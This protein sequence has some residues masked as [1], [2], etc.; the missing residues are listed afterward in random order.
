MRK[1]VL[2]F[3]LS[4]ILT[5]QINAAEYDFLPKQIKNLSR[6]RL[7]SEGVRTLLDEGIQAIDDALT[8]GVRSAA[9]LVLIAL[10][11]ALTKGF[12]GAESSYTEI[13]GV[14]AVSGVAAGD[15]GALIGA[16][17]R[18]IDDL[19]VLS[20]SL[21]PTLAI[22]MA[23]GGFVGTASVLQ[24]GTL[25]AAN[26]LITLIRELLLPLC[27][28]C[29]GL[30]AAAAIVPESRLGNFSSGLRKLISGT[31]CAMTTLFT[32]FLTLGGVLSGSADKM[33][34]KIA[35][36]TVSAAIP[37]VG[38]ILSE[39]SE[40]VLAGAGAARAVCG[41]LGIFAVLF[42]CLS[43][44][45]HLCIQYFLYKITA[46]LAASAGVSALDKYIEDI[47]SIFGLVLGM[48]GSCALLFLVSVLLSITMAVV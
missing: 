2:I 5:A 32:L 26:F 14:L 33:A 23:A 31:L 44:L 39:A 43:P 45:V 29:M 35:K 1:I 40:A 21:L 41:T 12:G 4:C 18:A 6:D 8:P 42:V 38:G 3:L 37:V 46:V 30:S 20:Q 22:A 10:L 28:C 47:G 27:Y 7:M 25:M 16:G 13:V 19:F 15:L 9:R 34:L 11:C 24:V 48:T 36:S 17:T